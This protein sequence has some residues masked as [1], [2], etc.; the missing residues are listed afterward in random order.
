MKNNFEKST[1][2][3]RYTFKE[4]LANCITHGIGVIF[5]IIAITIL[6]IY[7][8][9]NGEPLSI[10]SFAIY[11]TCIILMYL[12]STLYHSIPNEN[13]KKI[14]RIFDHSSIYLFIA[15][16]Y[17][18]IALLTMDGYLRV[19]ILIAVW[20]IAILGITF[21][22][23]TYKKM[24][25]FKKLSLALYLGMG[26]IAVFTIKP[27]IQTTSFKFFVW[28]LVGGLIY[29]LGTIFY[30]IKKIPYNHAIWHVFVLSA[31]IVHFLGIFLYLAA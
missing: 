19:G 28:I 3:K 8:I 4:E 11:G 13:I 17:T 30:S 1:S 23:V 9:K 21:K 5:G 27:I 2:A 31:S 6:L 26:W 14:L 22:I 12:S 24:D 25:N 20:S 15:G 18:P 16:T 10:V 29:T 7:S